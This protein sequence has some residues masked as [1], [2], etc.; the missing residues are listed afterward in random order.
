MP[1]LPEVETI[2]R[3]LAEGRRGGPPL[4]GQRITGAQVLWERTVAEPDAALF[5]ARVTG[6]EILSLG[7]RGKYLRLNLSR[8]VLLI[9]LRMS[10]DLWLEPLEEPPHRHHRVIFDLSSGYRLGFN[11]A[12]KFGRLWLVEDPAPWLDRLGPEPLDEAFTV[13]DFYARLHPRRRR[14]KPLLLDQTFLAGLGNIYTDEALHRAHLHPLRIANTL[15]VQEAAALLDSIRFVLREGLRQNGASI[16]WVY[17]GGG[18][19]NTFQV[20]QR[21]GQPCHTCGTPIQRII[22]GQRSTH[23][24]PRCQPFRE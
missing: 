4:P 23:F 14:L 3:L 18:F 12:R 1:E 17:R 15:T 7:R 24:C 22:V 8:D 16:D 20:Y 21:T 5:V 6:Q 13:A 19:Q 9:H 10:G 2:R 11:N